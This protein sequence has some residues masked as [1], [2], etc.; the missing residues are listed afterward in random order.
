MDHREVHKRLLKQ[1]FSPLLRPDGF[2]EADWA[3]LQK[4]GAWL[5]ALM[6]GDIEPI[7]KEQIHFIQVCNDMTPPISEPERIWKSYRNEVRSFKIIQRLGE[8]KIAYKEAHLELTKLAMPP[9]SSSEAT[10][11]IDKERCKLENAFARLERSVAHPDEPYARVILRIESLASR[12]NKLAKMWLLANA[13][14]SEDDSDHKPSQKNTVWEKG[15][16]HHVRHVFRG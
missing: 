2:T 8:K 5:H 7:T 12:G 1:S 6:Y 10:K 11:W 4:Y 16:I 15:R 9:F 13:R 3:Y 14:A